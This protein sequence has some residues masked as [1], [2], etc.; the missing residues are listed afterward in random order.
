MLWS[1][2]L[3]Q[4]WMLQY[5][6]PFNKYRMCLKSQAYYVTRAGQHKSELYELAKTG[7]SCF[8]GTVN[9]RRNVVGAG[10]LNSAYRTFTR[11]A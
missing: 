4:T 1:V 11:F 2:G 9:L 5:D 8:P 6:V 7:P 3:S 10:Q